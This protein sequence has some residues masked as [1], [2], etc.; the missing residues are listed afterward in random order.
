MSLSWSTLLE[1]TLAG[2]DTD[3]PIPITLPA[4]AGVSAGTAIAIIVVSILGS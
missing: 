4:T 1:L 3:S 2:L